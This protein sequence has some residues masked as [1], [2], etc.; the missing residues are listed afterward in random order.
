M[1]QK[2][3]ARHLLDNLTPVNY[4]DITEEQKRRVLDDKLKFNIVRRT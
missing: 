3:C 2:P 4:K 1:R